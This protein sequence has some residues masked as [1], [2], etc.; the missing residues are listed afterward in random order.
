[1]SPATGTPEPPSLWVPTAAVRRDTGAQPFVFIATGNHAVRRAVAV[2]RTS[3][4]DTEIT[5]GVA[6]GDRVIV[7]APATL[8]DGMAIEEARP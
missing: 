5:F 6:V 3:G 7:D 8:A 1:M 4:T 2:G